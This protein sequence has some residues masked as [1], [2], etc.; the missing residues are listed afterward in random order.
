VCA[1]AAGCG[2]GQLEGGASADCASQVR[3]DDRVYTSHGFTNRDATRF[4]EADRAE[5]HDVG[6]NAPGSVF[7]DQP[8]HVTA[9]SFAGYPTDKVLGVRFDEDSFGVYVAD[10]VSRAESERIFQE[11]RPDD[12]L[13]DR[14]IALAEALLREEVEEQRQQDAT[15]ESASVTVGSG[16]VKQTNTGE[17]CDSGR[18]LHLRLIGAFPHI[19]TTG[20]PGASAEEMTVRAVLLT[21]DAESGQVCL[22]GVKTGEVQPLPGATLLD[23]P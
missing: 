15:L 1:A 7:P 20:F 16:R 5:C 4:A 10:T 14:E 21:A 22:V 9:W 23:L 19:V 2:T 6:R 13:S 18:L 17:T 11:L 8:A 3:L 12:L